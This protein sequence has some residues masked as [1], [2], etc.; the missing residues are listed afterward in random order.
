MF[1]I[2]ANLSNQILISNTEK[3]KKIKEEILEFINSPLYQYRKFHNFYPVIGQ[4]NHFA[5]IVFVGEAPGFNEAKTGRPFVGNAGKILDKLFESI[6]LKRED[7]YITNILKDRPPENRDPLPEEIEAYAPFL[8]RQLE[9]IKPK[10]IVALGRYS[11]E[12]LFNLYN[13]KN[14]EKISVCHGKLFKTKASYGEINIIPMFH[15]A[16]ATYSLE[17]L[18]VLL[19]DFKN[20]TEFLKKP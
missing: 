12:H 11:M 5:K 19:K 17:K 15:P 10:V 4:G 7:I 13:L 6:D 18:E 14:I 9:I 1:Q 3:L 20:L 8:I 16:T 2:F